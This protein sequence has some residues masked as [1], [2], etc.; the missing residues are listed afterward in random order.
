MPEIPD[1]PPNS[2]NPRTGEKPAAPSTEPK[3]KLEQVTAGEV[4]TR[5]TPLGKKFKTIFTG[6]DAKGTA[7][8][9]LLDVLVPAAR[10]M[11]ADAV[12]AGVEK[13]LFGEVRSRSRRG[14]GGATGYVAYN[15]VASAIRERDE[16]RAISRRSRATHDFGEIILNTQVEAEE[17]IDRLNEQCRQY[18]QAS[19]ADLYDLIGISSNYTDEKWGWTTMIGS[20][21]DR[22][23]GGGYALDLP[24]TEQLDN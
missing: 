15:K 1:F 23:R 20:D 21:I 6:G 8:Y 18:G 24:R 10:D 12:S 9:V 11:I 3:K 22:V 5:K 19:V 4:K 13:M 7:N 14:S 2:I 17:V 16:P